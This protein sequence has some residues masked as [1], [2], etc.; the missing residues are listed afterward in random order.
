[1][2]MAAY[3]DAQWW[4]EQGYL[5]VVAD[6]RGTTGRG[7]RWDREIHECMKDVTLADQVDAVH[8]LADAVQAINTGQPVK[9]WPVRLNAFAG[10]VTLAPTAPFTACVEPLPPFA[11]RARLTAETCTLVENDWPWTLMVM[12]AVPSLC[13]VTVPLAST[14]STAGFDDVQPP[15]SSYRPPI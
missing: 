3:W 9:V 2:S 7:P 8:A 15:R 5:V 10:T 6:G 13:A 14:D 11:L 12:R 1:M 4:A